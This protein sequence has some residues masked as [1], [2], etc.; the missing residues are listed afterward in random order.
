MKAELR[1]FHKS[2]VT[3]LVGFCWATSLL[4]IYSTLLLYLHLDFTLSDRMQS[5]GVK[6]KTENLEQVSLMFSKINLPADTTVN[7]HTN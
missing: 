3:S 2:S 6:I 4:D 1:W 7:Q 5:M